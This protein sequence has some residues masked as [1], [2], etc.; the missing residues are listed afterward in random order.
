[1]LH[2]LML[3]NSYA[4]NDR[5]NDNKE[6]EKADAIMLR[7]PKKERNMPL[8]L[9]AVIAIIVIA[10]LLCLME[11]R[12]ELHYFKVT[13]DV[14]KSPKLNGLESEK[15]VVFLSDLHNK[16]YGS[17]NETLLEAVRQ[18]CPDLIL[19]G[20]D[21]LIGKKGCTF[22]PALDF[23]LK[24]PEICPV[25]YA[26]G[27]HEQ[28]MKE[29]PGEYGN[30]WETYRRELVQAGVHLLENERISV[31]LGE[32]KIQIT[33]LELPEKT[34]CKFNRYPIN[35]TDLEHCVGKG[36]DSVFQILLAHNPVYFKAYKEWGADLVLSGHLH[37]GIIRLP[38]IGGVITPQ[39]ILFPKYSGE[40]TVEEGHTIIVSRGLGTHTVNLRFLNEAELIVV[41]LKTEKQSE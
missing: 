2:P 14:V 31:Y 38:G 33:G 16:V 39:V 27:N 25:Y 17:N 5:I 41:H 10:G 4:K 9:F 29:H 13:H 11:A 6:M 30:V 24:L 34:Y 23:V 26:N 18:V 28:R 8:I 15:R 21:M 1:M 20:G 3:L 19:I 32:Q 36:D 37:G 7:T 12:R 22:R 35:K 40:M